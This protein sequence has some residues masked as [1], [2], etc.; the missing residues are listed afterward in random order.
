MTFRNASA[1]VREREREREH[2]RRR[3]CWKTFDGVHTQTINKL[4]KRD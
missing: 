3:K 1:G 4:T 2:H